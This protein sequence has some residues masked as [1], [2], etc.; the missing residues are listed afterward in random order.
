MFA[1]VVHAGR[2]ERRGPF[3]TVMLPRAVT[4]AM[5]GGSRDGKTIWLQDD[6]APEV[7]IPAQLGA[8]G[9]TMSFV[10]PGRMPAESSR[11]FHAVHE[12]AGERW[13]P[14]FPVQLEERLDRVIFQTSGERWAV[15]AVHGGRRPYFWPVLGP[16]GASVVRGQG[17]A[18]H[19]HHTG[20]GI[21]YGG[22]SEGGSTNIWSDWDEPPYGP[23]GRMVHRG[24]RRLAGGP[25]Y[26][27]VVED[28]TYVDAFGEPIVEEVRTI[29]CWF[30][31]ADAR[32]L[33]FRCEILWCRDRGPR[34]F[35]FAIRLPS[36]FDIPRTG[37]V[38]NAV[39]HPVPAASRAD[40]QYRTAWVDGSGPT[41]GPPPLPPDAPP[42]TLVD[43]PGARRREEHAAEGPWNG[44]ALF[45]HPSNFDYPN[46]AGKYAVVA[47]LTQAHYPPP[48]ARDGPFSF[49]QR[50]YIHAGDAEAGQVALQATS[51]TEP[52]SVEVMEYTEQ[53]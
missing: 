35:L 19:P 46:V 10:V 15:Y 9:Q 29:R 45:D 20:M 7:I 53:E 12:V 18:E 16:A 8:D 51:Y 37:R 4:R 40:R 11:C 22:H 24:F 49:V 39:N 32:Y 21:A 44:I 28:L 48:D 5:L 31:S 41:G 14:P 30:S 1:C 3:V 42:E 17:T 2:L 34:P 50:V 6:V 43:L 52:C 13:A 27:E 33:D 47:Q 38:S 26:G 36:C 23:G 25:V